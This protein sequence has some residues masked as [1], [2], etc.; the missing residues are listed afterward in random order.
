MSKMSNLDILIRER[1]ERGEEPIDIAYA[2]EIPVSW[3][4]EILNTEENVA[5]EVDQ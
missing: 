4:Y 5:N 3:V 1:L 2:L